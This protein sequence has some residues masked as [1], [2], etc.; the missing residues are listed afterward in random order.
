MTEE[1]I[2][3]LELYCLKDVKE[4]VEILL[5]AGYSVKIHKETVYANFHHRYVYYCDILKTV[6]S[7]TNTVGIPRGKNNDYNREEEICQF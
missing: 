5:N 6:E 1:Q 2:G 3:T 7:D 4:L